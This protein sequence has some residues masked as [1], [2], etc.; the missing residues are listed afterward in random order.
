MQPIPSS[1]LILSPNG[2]IYHLHLLPEQIADT[3][4][5][6]GD[7]NRVEMVSRYFDKIELRIQKREFVTHTG[8][9]NGKRVTVISSG[10]G[11][12]NIEILMTELDALVNIDLKTRTPN[13]S[14]RSLS[15]IRLGTSGALQ[16]DIPLDS[17]LVS[18]YG[19][20]L[21]TLM[22][23]YNLPQTENEMA[24]GKKLQQNL[25]LPFTP[26][27]VACDTDLKKQFA[28]D[29]LPG[30]T[31]TCPGFY[32]PQGRKLRLSPKNSE[33][34][35]K[36]VNFNHKN[37]KLTNFEMET[38]G[39]YAMAKLLGHKILSVNAIIAS[40]IN[41]QFSSNPQ[42]VIERMIETV[43]ERV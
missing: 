37:F 29:M 12:D 6:V 24:I 16:Q 1:E 33:Y 38:S 11:T 39:Y 2:S 31:L 25:A 5:T 15:I 3:I 4:L 21:D 41:H 19:I 9:L 34:I 18:E 8:L 35:E 14:T 30:N 10:M 20:G 23:F 22:C 17:L 36:L 28:F 43:L 26:Y 40:R 32:A 42:K 27:A 13:P 7:P